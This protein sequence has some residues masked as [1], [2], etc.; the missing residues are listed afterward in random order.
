MYSPINAWGCRPAKSREN[1]R[2]KQNKEAQRPV[3]GLSRTPAHNKSA[4]DSNRLCFAAVKPEQREKFFSSCGNKVGVLLQRQQRS[5][6]VVQCSRTLPQPA[7]GKSAFAPDLR[8]CVRERSVAPPTG[9]A[10]R[11]K[12]V[13]R[14]SL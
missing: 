10:G 14:R 5:I 3:A 8:L 12:R 6:R 11:G 1:Q 13:N 4:C 7:A 9:G 2:D